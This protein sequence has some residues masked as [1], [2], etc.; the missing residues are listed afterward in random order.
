MRQIDVNLVG[1]NIKSLLIEANTVLPQQVLAKLNQASVTENNDIAKFMLSQIIENAEIAKQKSWPLCQDTGMAVIFIDIGQEVNLINGD[2][3]D[4]IN[5]KVAEAYEQGKFRNSVASPITRINTNNNTPAIIHYNIVPGDKV[6]V[7]VAPKGFG[8]ENM[9]RLYM[10]N[11]TAGEEGIIESVVDAVKIA[12]GK[13]CPPIVIGVGIGGTVEKAALIAKRCLLR[14]LGDPAKDPKIAALEQQILTEVNKLNIGVQ[15]VGG[16]TTA[17]AVHVATFP[18]H[19]AGLPVAINIQ[20]HAA[21][22][23]K[24]VI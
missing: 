1:E 11:P 19:I 18:T 16:N 20:C 21:R 22:H 24:A 14:P 17:L 23:A 15:G 9:S 7:Y 3:N 5:T 10:L 2:I 6:Q 12:G 8:S 4:I 13:P